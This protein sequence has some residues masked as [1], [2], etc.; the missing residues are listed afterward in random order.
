MSK[1]L[2]PED[3]IALMNLKN[4]Y[5][6]PISFIDSE[7]GPEFHEGMAAGLVMAAELLGES[8]KLD[9][10][11]ARSLYAIVCRCLE[12]TLPVPTNK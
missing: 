12:E 3:K 4:E 7:D 5:E 9:P 8:G 11:L 6:M 2:T 1:R 10:V